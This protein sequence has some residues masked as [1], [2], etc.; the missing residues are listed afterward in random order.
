MVCRLCWCSLSTLVAT[1]SQ[2]R[3]SLPLTGPQPSKAE[4][5]CM[6]SQETL[7]VWIVAG[8][9]LVGRAVEGMMRSLMVLVSLVRGTVHLSYSAC[10][11]G[12]SNH[13]LPKFRQIWST[14]FVQCNAIGKFLGRK[15]ERSSMQVTCMLLRRDDGR[16]A[17]GLE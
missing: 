6:W 4:L 10:V 1:C 2:V 8:C 14:Y 16:N 15:C 12:R 5:Q 13:K 9:C 7:E 11:N 3:G 17:I